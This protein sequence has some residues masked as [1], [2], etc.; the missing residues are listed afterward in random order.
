M[1]L[2]GLVMWAPWDDSAAGDPA[3]ADAA[4]QRDAALAAA[5]EALK[6]FNTIDHRHMDETVGNWL[7]LSGG[8]LHRDLGRDRRR[9]ITQAEATGADTTATVL[10]VAVSAFDSSAGE[11]TVIGAL[12]VQTDPQKGKS[13]SSLERFRVLVQHVGSTWKITYLEAVKAGS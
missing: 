6:A 2:G 5:S 9:I 1:L 3:V 13:G 10:K 12:R 8:A 7:R 11:A 4:H